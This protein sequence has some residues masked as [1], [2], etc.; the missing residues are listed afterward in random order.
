MFCRGC[1]FRIVLLAD[2]MNLSL[3]LGLSILVLLSWGMVGVFQKLAVNRIS[4]ETA[5]AWVSAGFM[6]L[7][8]LVFP[9]VSVFSYSSS[10]L[11]CALLN[12]ICNGFGILFLMAAM[13]QGG[14]AS[15][16]ESLAALYPI[17]VVVLA[18]LLL[19]EK[20]SAFHLVGAGCAVL[21]GIL[22]AAESPSQH[23]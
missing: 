6:L 2:L 23:Q 15:I 4:T 22:L 16:V 12:G 9:S 17:F 1:N 13:R 5:L 7:Q 19:R 21:A 18:P 14:K 20:L 8:P 11:I 10:S 3:W